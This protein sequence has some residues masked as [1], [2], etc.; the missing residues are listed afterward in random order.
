MP[1]PEAG[2]KREDGCP[3][4]ELLAAA[5]DGGRLGEEDAQ[6]LFGH[7]AECEACLGRIDALS[8]PPALKKL[9]NAP[10]RAAAPVRAVTIIR[11]NESGRYAFLGPPRREGDLG[12]LGPYRILHSVGRGGSAVVFLGWDDGLDIPV[13]VKVLKDRDNKAAGERLRREASS[14]AQFNHPRIVR[15]TK[16]YLEHEPPFFTMEYVG[17]ETLD[18]R[19]GHL[20]HRTA[21]RIA[22]DVATGLAR[23]HTEGWVHQ[24]IKPENVV[25]PEQAKQKECWPG[26]SVGSSEGRARRAPPARKS[27]TSAWHSAAAATCRPPTGSAPATGAPSRSR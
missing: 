14:G 12:T 11:A 8:T 19:I 13:A 1:S 6:G 25:L 4:D 20:D 3:P 7:I 23:L 2:W 27:S 18:K 9:F 16:L 5:L 22:L 26:A 10:L 24:D 15:V 17:G 21:A